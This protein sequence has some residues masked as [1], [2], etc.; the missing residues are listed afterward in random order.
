MP[1]STYIK[2]T[3][4]S[5]GAGVIRKM[6]EEGIVLKKEHGEYLTL[7]WEIQIWTRRKKYLQNLHALQAAEKKTFTDTCPTQVTWKPV[8]PWQKK[9]LLNRE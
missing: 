7:A 8:T 5:K 9:L 3:M 1:V 6:F 2:E 4:T